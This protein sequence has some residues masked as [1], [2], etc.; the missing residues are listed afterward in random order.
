VKTDLVHFYL[1]QPSL[2]SNKLT[3]QSTYGLS[4]REMYH[5][6]V[7]LQTGL[8]RQFTVCLL[9]RCLHY[10]R[11]TAKSNALSSFETMV[12]VYQT[13]RCHSKRPQQP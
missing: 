12:P 5:W 13:T 6:S 8:T 11:S 9:Y 1:K 7:C 4:K 10:G 2:Q 3:R